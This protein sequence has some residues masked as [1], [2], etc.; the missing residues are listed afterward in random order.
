MRSVRASATSRISSNAASRMRHQ[1]RCSY[2]LLWPAVLS[3][4]PQDAHTRN[5]PLADSYPA[6]I[7]FLPWELRRPRLSQRMF[8]RRRYSAPNSAPVRNQVRPD[9]RRVDVGGDR[10][11]E[12]FAFAV[13][14]DVVDGGFVSA[15][16]GRH[17]GHL[18]HLQV[19][20]DVGRLRCCGSAGRSK[21]VPLRRPTD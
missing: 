2:L 1:V 10:H 18:D 13:V 20:A 17:P 7:R 6:I 4:C 15:H 12:L 11:R 16:F 9:L 5:R 19:L 14:A 21:P 8:K 3:S